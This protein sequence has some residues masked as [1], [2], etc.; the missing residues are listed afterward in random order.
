MPESQSFMITVPQ[1]WELEEYA[2]EKRK[3]PSIQDYIRE[4]IRRDIEEYEKSKK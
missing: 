4:L 1:D 2:K 3:F